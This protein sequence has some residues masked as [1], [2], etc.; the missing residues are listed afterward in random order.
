VRLFLLFIA[1]F[2]ACV[3]SSCATV[4]P[5]TEEPARRGILLQQQYERHEAERLKIV[6]YA[7]SLLGRKDLK[8]VNRWFRNDCSGYVLGV[9]QTLGYRVSFPVRPPTR[10][11]SLLLHHVL[12]REGLTY[13]GQ[14]PNIADVVFFTGT[15]D[16]GLSKV[17]HVGIVSG[18]C[19]DGTIRVLNYTS[20]GVTVL[21]MN[22][23]SPSV[24][25]NQDGEVKN[26]FLRKKI[27]SSDSGKV[28]SGELFCCFGDLLSYCTL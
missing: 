23:D 15:V 7:E 27:T 9:Y 25:R 22:L 3:L 28:L 10:Q 20:A 19:Q 5:R 18:I 16:P 17:S 26:D 21:H 8:S 12:H 1:L 2:A 24:H 11:I 14:S 6:E 4:V 13:T